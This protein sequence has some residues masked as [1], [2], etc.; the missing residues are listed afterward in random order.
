MISIIFDLDD[1]L[2]FQKDQFVEVVEKTGFLTNKIKMTDLYNHFRDASEHTYRLQ[3]QGELT[4]E[5][6][7]IIRIREAYEKIGIMLTDKN[8]KEWQ[9]CYEEAQKNIQLSFE[10]QKLLSDCKERGIQLGIITNGPSKHQRMKIA[11]L[12]LKKWIPENHIVVSG[13]INI[14]KPNRLIF[15]TLQ[16]Q[17]LF[18]TEETYY[19]G[20]NFDNDV[21]GANKVGWLPIWL[22]NHSIEKQFES[23]V[24]EVNSH[25]ELIEKIRQIIA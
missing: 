18:E 4:L 24:I 10:I 21:I 23:S 25:E 20:D 2:Y 5:Q 19:V 14:S 11:A 16:N 17:M 3:T 9:L 13:D 22:N 8:A 15:E 6:M 7:R 1:T 12:G